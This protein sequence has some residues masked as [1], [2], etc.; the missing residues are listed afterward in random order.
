MKTTCIICPVGCEL[1]IN[2]K[3]G[4]LV[5]SGNNCLRGEHYGKS[6]MTEP[7]RV[8]TAVI[9]GENQICSVKTDKPILKN[10][11]NELL[12]FLNS[13]PQKNYKIGDIVFKNPLGFDCN[14][15]V[16]GTE[17]I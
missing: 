13:A 1:E 11:I 7:K 12:L 17:K 10:K 5:V 9:R 3:D 16:T 15:I 2:E 14:V 8:I 6:E 4:K